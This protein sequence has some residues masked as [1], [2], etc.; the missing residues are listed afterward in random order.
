MDFS[1]LA[2]RLTESG[3][4]PIIASF[5]IGLLAAISP[6]PMATNITAMAYISRNITDRRYVITSGLLYMLGRIVSYSIVG[7]LVVV[8]GISIPGVAEALQDWG[9]VILGPLFIVVGILMLGIVKIPFIQGGGRLSSLA[10]R[11]AN[12]GRLGAFLMGVVLALA[13]CPYTAILFFA[14]LIPLA[15]QS[16]GGI[17]FPAAFALGTGL[18]VLVFAILL[19]FGITKVSQWFNKV[20]AVEKIMRKIVALVFIGAGIYYVVS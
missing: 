10:E 19:S 9:E 15:M 2:L 6:C 5:L 3:S 12:K 18:P 20:T 7:L 4:L 11:V 17:T 8:I 14:I 1:E 16:T 13:F